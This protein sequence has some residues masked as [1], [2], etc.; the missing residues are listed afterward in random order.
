MLCE[1][2]FPAP[3]IDISWVADRHR[4]SLADIGPDHVVLNMDNE[5]GISMSMAAWASVRGA[6][7]FLQQLDDVQ[8][9]VIRRHAAEAEANADRERKEAVWQA[10]DNLAPGIAPAQEF[11]RPPKPAG[12]AR[13]G[14][15]WSDDE[16]ARLMAAWDAGEKPS[17]IAGKLE[18]GR[19]AVIAR[20]VK[21]GRI[22]EEGA[23]LRW[24]AS[25]PSD[26]PLAGSTE[27]G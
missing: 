19:T 7:A 11:V 3:H 1:P 24:P 2:M 8:H 10:D 21:L 26:A 15:P 4:F 25:R 20:L 17:E 14:K 9:A 13:R 27:T 16:E 23:Q 6:L 18:R 12:P 5:P 22:D